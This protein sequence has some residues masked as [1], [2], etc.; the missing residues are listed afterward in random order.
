MTGHCDEQ[1]IQEYLDG[2]LSGPMCTALRMHLDLCPS[3]ASLHRS[4]GAVNGIL[5]SLPLDQ[6]PP[7]MTENVLARIMDARKETNLDRMLRPRVLASVVLLLFGIVGGVGALLTTAQGAPG[8]G[9]PAGWDRVLT[10]T[11]HSIGLHA[12]TV[13]ALVMGMLPQLFSAEALE[14]T[15]AVLLAVPLMLGLDQILAKRRVTG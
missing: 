2:R 15:L 6:A 5:R 1:V 9:M 12:E 13:S 4:A 14:V 10:G 8:N 7:D 11:L 3:C